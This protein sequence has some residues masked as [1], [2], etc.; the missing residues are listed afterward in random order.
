MARG[1]YNQLNE[2]PIYLFEKI[3]DD[4]SVDTFRFWRLKH[5]FLQRSEYEQLGDT[6]TLCDKVV[7]FL[8]LFSPAPTDSRK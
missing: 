7:V 6:V 4:A 3:T 1:F 5:I 2:N 8:V